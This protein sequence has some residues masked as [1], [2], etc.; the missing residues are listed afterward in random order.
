MPG[1]FF[2]TISFP[3][4]LFNA[5]LKKLISL[6]K[7]TFNYSE[8]DPEKRKEFLETI[9]NI[10]PE[11]I[12]YSDETGIDDNEVAKKGWELCGK[13]FLAQKKAERTTRYNITAAL[14][15]N[16]L[17]AP[18]LFEGY[19]SQATYEVYVEQVLAPALRPGMVVVID[20]A[21]F[22]KSKKIVDLIEAVNCKILFLPPYSPDF[23]PI[24]HHWAAVKNAIR[25]AANSAINFYQGAINALAQLCMI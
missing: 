25:R 10:K 24:E 23:N 3:W 19:S 7:K 20:N 8:A 2:P 16:L 22:H 21:S 5:L 12:V 17:F 1:S 13:R 11:N 14:N 6:L 4:L 9:A 15:K 18:F